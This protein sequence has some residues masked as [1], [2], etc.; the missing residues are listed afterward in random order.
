MYEVEEHSRAG[1]GDKNSTPTNQFSELEYIP[2]MK[3]LVPL[4]EL[5]AYEFVKLK[6]MKGLSQCTKIQWIIVIGGSQ[7]KSYQVW[8][9]WDISRC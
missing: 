9:H 2:I 6:S 4:M 3:A 5:C 1:A 7:Q 8:K